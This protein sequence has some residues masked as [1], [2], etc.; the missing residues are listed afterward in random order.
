M[1]CP[2]QKI[3]TNYNRVGSK[4][5]GEVHTPAE[6]KISFDSCHGNSCAAWDRE[7]NRCFLCFNRTVK[8]V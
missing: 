1:Y 3:I 8:E 7:K 2:F 6:T 5:S 4:V